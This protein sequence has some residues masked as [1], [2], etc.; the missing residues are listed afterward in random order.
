MK[1]FVSDSD[2]L[3]KSLFKKRGHE[4]ADSI[5]DSFSLV[6]FTGGQDISPFLYGERLLSNTRPFFPRDLDEV[7]LWKSLDPKFPKVGICRGAQLGNVL[8]GGTLWQDVDNHNGMHEMLLHE[9][10]SKT[11][12]TSVHHQMCKLTSEARLI[13]SAN[14]SKRKSSEFESHSI[15]NNE[16]EDPEAFYYPNCDFLG[17]QFHPE[18]AH[19]ESEAVFWKLFERFYE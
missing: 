12:V 13:A 8:C 18:Y 5:E 7:Y 2:P 11:H 3:V 15:A 16:W 4:I 17:V 10:N 6:I 9:D 19:K 14:Q 1:V